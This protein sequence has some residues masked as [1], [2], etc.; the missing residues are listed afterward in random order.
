[1]YTVGIDEAGRGA[2]A[3][4]VVVAVVAIPSSFTSRVRTLPRLRDSKKL[5]PIQRNVWFD[6]IKN[7]HDIF[8]TSARVYP[9]PIDRKNISVSAN[10]AA[11]RALDRMFERFGIHPRL[12][13]LDGS[14][15]LHSTSHSDL[16]AK[17]IIRGDEKFVS[18]KLA[19]IVAKVTRDTYMIRLNKKFPAYEFP[20]HKGYG[21]E[22]HRSLINTHGPSSAHRLTYLKN[23]VE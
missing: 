10:I 2:L 17:T 3:G 9:G 1:M 7:T 15:Y 19:S 21:T 22:L 13:M 6:Y 4:P 14:L 11:S 16:N 8:Y 5:S 12:I 23:W 20:R 18:I